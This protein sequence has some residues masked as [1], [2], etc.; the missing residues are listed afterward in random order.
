MTHNYDLSE[1]TKFDSLASY[2]WDINGPLKTLHQIN[3]IRLSYISE[4]I[5]LKG[6]NIVDIGCGGGIL[7]E[8]LAKMGATLTGIDMNASVI[9]TAKLHQ[10]LSSLQ[11]EY[12]HTSVENL[13]AERAE[14]YDAVTC[15]ELLEHVPNPLSIIESCASLVK[16]GG[17]LFFSTLNRTVK[18]YAL[19]IL[20]AEY[21]FQLLPKNTHDYAKFI[22]PSE[23]AYFL[24]QAGLRVQELKGISYH[25]FTKTFSM[26]DDISINYLC[27]VK[28]P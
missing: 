16:P 18:S 3:P 4:K 25:L 26:S 2:W 19:A 23:L 27:H 7:T 1:L 9:E 12:L 5:A 11:I 24:R 17:D 6:K 15:L 8:S 21:V 14:Q 20:A 22:K 13:A 10:L 28:K